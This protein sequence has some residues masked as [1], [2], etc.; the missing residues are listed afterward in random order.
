MLNAKEKKIVGQ[1]HY[2]AGDKRSHVMT[3]DCIAWFEEKMRIIRKLCKALPMTKPKTD[4]SGTMLENVAKLN[5]R[6][7]YRADAGGIM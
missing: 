2:L 6:K 1:I 7:N 3:D 5:V 4:R